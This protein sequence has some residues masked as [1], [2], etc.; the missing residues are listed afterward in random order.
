MCIYIYIYMYADVCTYAYICTC[1][2]TST[3]NYTTAQWVWGILPNSPV[4][5]RPL[6]FFENQIK[7]C[8]QTECIALIQSHGRWISKRHHGTIMLWY[9]MVSSGTNATW[10]HIVKATAE[11]HTAGSAQHSPKLFSQHRTAQQTLAATRPPWAF[12]I[13]RSVYEPECTV[14]YHCEKR[15][16]TTKWNS[17]GR[18]MA[19]KLERQGNVHEPL[20]V[21]KWL[22][23]WVQQATSAVNTWRL[24]TS[25][26]H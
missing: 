2:H 8:W 20:S 22:V 26:F 25:M 21:D 1:V 13:P 5:P 3:C 12:I 19:S 14:L 10:Y 6:P 9:P 15:L 16:H 4:R 7:M 24:E 18:P 23:G 11:E 17:C